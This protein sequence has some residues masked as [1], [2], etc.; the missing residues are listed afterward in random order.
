MIDAR[1]AA[2]GRVEL[3]LAE[4]DGE[5]VG[6]VGC[7]E[8]DAD[9]AQLRLLLVEPAARNRGLGGQLVDHCLRFARQGG[10]RRIA[11]W[12]NDILVEARRLYEKAGFALDEE[13]PHHSFGHDL[14]GQFW[15]R[16][17]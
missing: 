1:I 4:V 3:W 15:S 12:T 11:L 6:C 10:Y 16:D 9:T 13:E 7:V 8:R 17:L 2:P 14:V 5:P